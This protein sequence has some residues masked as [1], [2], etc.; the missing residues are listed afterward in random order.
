MNNEQPMT[1]HEFVAKYGNQPGYYPSF[2]VTDMDE[3]RE[4]LLMGLGIE[5]VETNQCN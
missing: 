4:M 1:F 3:V 5:L 2:L